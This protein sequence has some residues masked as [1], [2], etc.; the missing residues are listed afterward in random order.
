MTA[1]A[2]ARPM[3]FDAGWRRHGM[4]LGLVV[5]GLALLFHRD[6]ADLGGIYWHSETF[7]HCL[8]VLPIFGWLVW[9]RREGLAELAPTGWWPGLA[10]VGGGALCWLIGAAAGVAVLRHLGLVVMMQGSAIA[11][12]G[13]NIARALAFPLAWLFFLVPFGQS[14][15]APLQDLTVRQVMPLLH[16]TDVPATYDG[17]LI[18]TPDGVFEV[19]EECSGARFVL[20]MLAFAVLAANVCF[21][22]WPRRIAFV[23]FALA[24]PVLANGV[25]A[26]GTIYAAHLTSLEA[27]TGFD[28]IVY[29]WIFFGVVMAAV[30]ALAWP[31]F[32]RDADAPWFDPAR[33]QAAPRLA[34]ALLPV[35]GASLGIAV[36]AA[37]WAHAI[38]A[39]TAALPARIELPQVPGWRRV[40]IDPRAPWTPNYPGADHF[41]IGRYA[42]ASGATV[43]LAIA[44]QA[45]QREGKEIVGFDIG[46]IVEHGQ[47]LRVADLAPLDGGAAMRIVH[48]GP[49]EREVVTW[50]RIGSILTGDPKRVKLETLRVKLTGGDQAAVAVLVS[51]E[52]QGSTDTHATIERFVGAL[53]PIEALADRAAGRR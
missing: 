18:V 51:A 10:V 17:V 12:L 8:L 43:D 41:L 52:K 3:L 30:L 34:A 9:Q 26:W 25:R 20:A 40:A 47:W 19:A 23:A 44:A 2:I 16:L 24:A 14:I 32:D 37:G 1:A 53:G 45:S 13:P 36:A 48:A 29:G 39:H 15:E 46:P 5:F 21:R 7:G 31:W 50:L 28:H 6:V 49:V 35:A 22:T 38:D 27:A 11:I 33:L 42:D 4:L